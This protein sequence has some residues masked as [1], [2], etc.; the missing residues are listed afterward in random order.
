MPKSRKLRSKDNLPEEVDDEFG[1]FV[2]D[3]P[4]TVSAKMTT[5][6]CDMNL[7]K[8]GLDNNTKLLLLRKLDELGGPQVCD[9]K[10]R[11]LNKLCKQ[12]P[13]QFGVTNSI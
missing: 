7:P 10:S 2:D 8:R 11:V 1:P 9:Q 5:Y 6:A 13:M 12:Y 3:D 4:F